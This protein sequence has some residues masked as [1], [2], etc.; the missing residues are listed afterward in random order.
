[1]NN[2][3]LNFDVNKNLESITYYFVNNEKFTVPASEIPQNVIDLYVNESREHNNSARKDRIY[4][5]YT[6]FDNLDECLETNSPHLDEQVIQFE[7]HKLFESAL[8][9][10]LPEQKSIIYDIYF[11]KIPAVDIAKRENV[12]KAAISQKLGRAKTSLKKQIK[13]LDPTYNYCS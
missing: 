3:F 4:L 12:S 6:S 13:L 1:M 8:D 11:K 5:S 2:I 9:M 7:T 10:I